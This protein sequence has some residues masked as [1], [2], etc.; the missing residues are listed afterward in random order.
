METNDWVDFWRIFHP[1]KKKFSW[2]QKNPAK[3][4][5]LDYFVGT[6]ELTSAILDPKIEPKWKSDHAPVT[7]RFNVNNQQR[8]RGVW[9]FN[10]SLLMYNDFK[11]V[12]IE[13]VKLHKTIYA[14]TPYNPELVEN[15][16]NKDIQ[17]TISYRLFWETLL[18]VLRGAVITFSSKKKGSSK[19]RKNLN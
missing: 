11:K 14:A 13:E 8:G 15:I 10:N 16:P 9:K 1:D 6:E 3:Y 12:I 18:T 7:M 19:G 4:A 2:S 17:L 5:R